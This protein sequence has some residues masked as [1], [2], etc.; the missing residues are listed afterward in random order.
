[1]LFNLAYAYNDFDINNRL[2]FLPS[3]I[4]VQYVYTNG[5]LSTHGNAMKDLLYN[6][7]LSSNFIAPNLQVNHYDV[8]SFVKKIASLN[9]DKQNIDDD[10]NSI[11]QSNTYSSIK[12]FV[13]RYSME[14]GMLN[15]TDCTFFTAHSSGAL[16]VVYNIYTNDYALSETTSFLVPL[17]ARRWHNHQ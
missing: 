9:Y 12:D 6:A 13:G 8:E 16:S 11:T 10:I 7:Y 14:N 4:Y 1:M 2:Q 15:V 17:N 3:D 5:T